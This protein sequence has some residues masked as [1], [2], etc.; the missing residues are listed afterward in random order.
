MDELLMIPGPVPLHPRVIN[1]M[2]KQMIN[3]R[4][5]EFGRIMDFCVEQFRK[6]FATEEN[7]V[8][9]ISGSG[10][11]GMEAAVSNFVSGKI[12]CIENGKFGERFVK[13]GERYCESVQRL[14]F[15]WGKSIDLDRVEE[16]LANGA[17]AVTMVH[18]ETSTGI[19]NP[20][21]K[22]GK[23][24]EKYDALFILDA[25]TSAGGDVVL[26]DEWGVDV[27]VVGS[28]KCLGAPPG[29]AAV[30]VSEK[31]WSRTTGKAPY[32]LD[33]ESYKKS[34]NKT[35]SQTPYTPALPLFFALY[36]ALKIIEEETIEKRIERHRKLSEGCRR[37]MTAMGLEL[38]P[39]LNEY[40]RYSNTVTAVKMPDGITDAQL[41]GT[42][43]KEFGVIIAGGQDI[44]KGRIFRIGNMGNVGVKEMITTIS[45]VELTL[46]R[47][48]VIDEVGK[49]IDAA[50]EVYGS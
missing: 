6:I 50:M 32:Y 49:G 3:H 38:F 46:H 5:E 16:A 42:V 44:L 17:E 22:I 13:I 1:A 21:E 4:G 40:S 20:A 41:R 34:L 9:I 7:D 2:A 45:A 14:K 35:P 47:Y 15:E 23:L 26:V 10:T 31:A 27:A 33:L 24:A 11:S 12:V 29:I 36:E 30:V 18:N 39:E 43:K 28:Q 48:G 37:A 8:L 25:I 19:L